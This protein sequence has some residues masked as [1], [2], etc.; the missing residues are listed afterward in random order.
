MAQVHVDLQQILNNLQDNLDI[1]EKEIIAK[2]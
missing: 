2:K 1:I